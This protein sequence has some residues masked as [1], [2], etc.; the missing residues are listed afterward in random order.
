[1]TSLPQK[2]I[3]CLCWHVHKHTHTQARF[4]ETK[5]RHTHISS[6][7]YPKHLDSCYMNINW[8]EHLKAEGCL[9]NLWSTQTGKCMRQPVMHDCRH[10]WVFRLR[11]HR[12]SQTRCV[13][14]RNTQWC[15]SFFKCI[16]L[17]LS[18]FYNILT[19][20][21]ILSLANPGQCPV[22]VNV[23]GAPEEVEFQ[24]IYIVTKCH[25]EHF[26]TQ[27]RDTETLQPHQG[28]SSKQVHFEPYKIYIF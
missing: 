27:S 16:L 3:L 6:C 5:V 12:A 24:D 20:C 28:P 1:M 26:M 17:K 15:S 18:Y 25:W 7:N 19:W 9:K 10:T 23:T 14:L 22:F 21:I 13:I 8:H 2:N 4:F 11:A